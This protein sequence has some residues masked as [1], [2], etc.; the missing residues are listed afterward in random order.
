MWYRAYD[1]CYATSR[2]GLRWEKPLL[3]V[4]PG[5]N[6]VLDTGR[7][8]ASNTVWLDLDEKDP[9]RRFKMVSGVPGGE[10]RVPGYNTHFE[11]YV[12]PDGIH[13][14]QSIYASPTM[15]DRSTLFHNPFRKVWVFS[16]KV[17]PVIDAPQP[18]RT[19]VPLTRSRAYRESREF[20]SP[21]R[22]D[23]IVPWVGADNLDPNRNDR[24]DHQ[25]LGGQH[26]YS[27]DCVA[28]ESILLGLFT[29]FHGNG[30]GPRRHHHMN[31]LTL[32]YSRDGFHWRR[33]DR[34][35]FL[36]PGEDREQWNYN[37]IQSAGGCCLV[38]GDEL[39]FYVS[40]RTP[41]TCNTGLA[42]LRRDGFASMDAGDEEGVLIT[43]PVV[44]EGKHLFVNVDC[45][46]G[47]LR[48]DVLRADVM[49]FFE[50]TEPV[51]EPFTRGKCLPIRA[52]KTLQRVRWEGTEDLSE[53]ARRPV[54]FRFHLRKGSLYSFWVSPDESGAS[55]G[56]VAAGGPGF[57][58][59]RDTVGAAAG[60]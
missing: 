8:R 22:A 10:P 48:V 32:G 6:I 39:W 1:T 4:T 2:D 17:R 28:Y 42:T 25:V 15:R 5:T 44:F 13:W 35:A 41:N 45:P 30:A 47:D 36:G 29:I 58:G 26:L 12:S 56:Y 59:P 31:D 21:W 3:D 9:Q 18:D 49:N 60:P 40:G 46:E 53:L 23:Q 52:D 34:R 7:R 11:F 14:G 27:L 38:V 57:T 50:E 51:I 20:A 37:N 55:H 33:P 43:R 24:V 19:Y 16:I 54:R